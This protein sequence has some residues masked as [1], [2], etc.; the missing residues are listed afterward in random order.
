MAKY[1]RFDPRNKKK[2]KDKYRSEKKSPKYEASKNRG[3]Y[4]EADL[5]TLEKIGSAR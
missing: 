3:S 1:G 5:K 2:S 4:S